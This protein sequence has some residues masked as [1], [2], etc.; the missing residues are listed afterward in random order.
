MLTIIKTTNKYIIPQYFKLN[1]KKTVVT[2]LKE[3]RFK[4]HKIYFL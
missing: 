4:Q 3:K 1:K 2:D